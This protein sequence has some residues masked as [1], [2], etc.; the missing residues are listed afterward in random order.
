[1][2]PRVGRY[3]A[4]NSAQ[5]DKHG[6]NLASAALL[7]QWH[8]RTHNTLTPILQ[9][10]MKLGGIHAEKEA[11]NFIMDKVGKPHI[12]S[13]ISHVTAHNS[14]RKAKFAIIPDLH[15]HNFP[16]GKQAVNDSGVILTAEAF[17]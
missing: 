6:A 3:F 2:A 15:A 8:H 14:A 12:S 13:Y 4:K 7:G 5:L 17:F 11:T 9:A 1:M 10:M 16:P